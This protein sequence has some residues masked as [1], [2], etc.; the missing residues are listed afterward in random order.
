MATQKQID[1]NRKNAQK[2]TGPTSPDGKNV[3]KFN[4]LKHGLR[5]E[6]VVLPGE[7]AAAFEAEL[8]GWSDDW[9][10]RSHTCAV[11]V[12]RA[13]S[14]SW[15]LRRCVRVENAR[16]T[17]LAREAARLFDA[18]DRGRIA[19]AHALL[20]ADP[21][22]AFKALA[23]TR[24]GFDHLIA[25]VDGL[26]AACA[27]PSGWNDP[28]AHLDRFLTLLGVPAGTNPYEVSELAGSATRLILTN[29]PSAG[30]DPRGPLTGEQA[31]RVAAEL[32]A[33]LAD[34]RLGLVEQR[35]ELPP[36]ELLRARAVDVSTLDVSKAGTLLHRYEMAHDRSLRATINQLAALRK[37]G[38]DLVGRAEESA[39]PTEPNSVAERASDQGVAEELSDAGSSPEGSEMGPEGPP[40][41]SPQA[42]RDRDGRVWP[43]EGA[44]SSPPA[45][46]EGR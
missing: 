45:A 36:T 31:G 28:C 1:A 20:D 30:T 15:R 5:A 7:N 38:L 33:E 3:T 46:P 42:D 37:S 35:S 12:E 26:L 34:F 16:L 43:V 22:G 11:L 39:A 41:A 29:D 18:E 8:K 23:R 6:H 19:E 25:L 21:Q 14:A 4:G 10:P 40:G 13:A 17:G 44:V 2:S 32:R 27:E 9:N 24:T